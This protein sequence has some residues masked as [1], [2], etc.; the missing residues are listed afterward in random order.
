MANHIA[1]MHKGAFVESGP[2]GKV[3]KVP[4]HEYTRSLFVS[5]PVAAGL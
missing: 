3:V 5:F 4:L 1:I 2:T